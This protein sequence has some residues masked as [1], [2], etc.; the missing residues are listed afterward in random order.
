MKPGDRT[1][2]QKMVGYCDDILSMTSRFGPSFDDYMGDLAYRYAAAMCILQIGELINRLS[3]DALSENVQIP[4]RMIR[5]TR[6]IFA[7]SYERAEND[8]VWKTIIEDIPA[9]RQ[10]LQ[11]I[12]EKAGENRQEV[13]GWR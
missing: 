4:W 1:I 13:G 7:H 11:A 8:V 5:A 9:L 10:Q 12:L 2:L 6:N 3:S